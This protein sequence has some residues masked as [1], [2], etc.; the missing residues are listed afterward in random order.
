MSSY[1]KLNNKG[2]S[3]IMVIISFVFIVALGSIMA[4][5]AITN[6]EMKAINKKSK[7]SFYSAE[8][9]LDEVKTSLTEDVADSLALAY[10]KVLADFSEKDNAARKTLLETEFTNT[11]REKFEVVD[12]KFSSSKLNHYLGETKINAITGNGAVIHGSDN[13]ENL[14]WQVTDGESIT[15]KGVKVVYTYNNYTTSITTDIKIMFPGASFVSPIGYVESMPY[16]NYSLI[17]NNGL[18]AQTSTHVITGNV[19]VGTEGINISSELNTVTVKDGRVISAGNITV[20][21]KAS[22]IVNGV[23]SEVWAT[24]LITTQT[25]KTGNPSRETSIL[26]EGSTYIKDDLMLDAKLSNVEL[27]GE[28]Y[29]YSSGTGSDHNSAIM[30][31]A[32]NSSLKMN[33][34]NKLTIAGRA[35]LNLSSSIV[36]YDKDTDH[37][38]D[39]G[40]NTNYQTGESLTV[41]GSQNAYLLPSEFIAVGHNPVS[42]GEYIDYYGKELIDVSSDA[43]IFNDPSI[44][45]NE[46]KLSDYVELT[47]PVTRA[48]YKFGGDS[49]VVYYYLKFKSKEL[50]TIYFKNFSLCYPDKLYN[51]FPINDI[52]VNNSSGAYVTAGNLITYNG[53]PQILKGNNSNYV[54]EYAT[55]FNNLCHTLQKNVPST[56]TLFEN[57]INVERVKTDGLLHGGGQASLISNGKLADNT[58][59]YVNIIDGDFTFNEVGK[60]GIIVATGDVNLT[61][62]FTGM[63]ISGGDITLYTGAN[64]KSNPTLVKQILLENTDL[65]NYFVDLSSTSDA[66]DDWKAVNISQLIVYE[67]WSKN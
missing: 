28:Y 60:S 51:G 67:N 2:A 8:A 18:W 35:F 49:N 40:A 13:T 45:A 44:Y 52:L 34:L 41:K 42:W 55:Q 32:A 43:V 25:L 38:L 7:Q 21:D 24:N 46:R 20:K 57:I 63:I 6:M 64:F 11:L 1:T 3:L 29:G 56:K 36:A 62:N 48:F 47:D 5:I 54:N 12:N 17:A 10:E 31:N 19:C 16:V 59:Y 33:R 50:A 39:S 53:R 66:E 37:G 30:I 58:E 4:S 23:G 27:S 22:F 61:K 9:A 65:C 14:G 15:I 26:I